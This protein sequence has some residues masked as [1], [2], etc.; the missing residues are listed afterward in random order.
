MDLPLKKQITSYAQIQDLW[1]RGLLTQAEK[2]LLARCRRGEELILN[3]GDRP[4]S[5]GPETE[6]R[7]P[8]LRYLILGGCRECRVHEWGVQLVGAYISG[9]LDLGFAKAQGITRLIACRFDKPIETLQARFELLNLS[10][11]AFPGLNG[12]D[13]KIAGDVFLKEAKTQGEV[14]LSGAEIGGQLECTGA[15]LSNESGDALNAQG[16]KIAESVFLEDAETQGEVSFAGAEIGGQLNCTGARL[17]NEG[18]DALNAQG[19]KVAGDVFLSEADTNGDV[20]FSSAE[21]GGQLECTGARLSNESGDAL[22]AQGA[23][24]AE[25]V[26][27][28]DADTKGDVRFA[29]AEIGGTLDCTGARLSNEDGHALNAQGAKVAGDVFLR[30]ADT[31]GDVRFSSAEIGGQLACNGARLTNEGGDAL[32]AQRAVTK[33]SFFWTE[34]EEISGRVDLNSSHAGDL[35]DDTESW[36][37]VSDLILDNFTYNTLYGPLDPAFRKGWLEKGA[38]VNGDF[39][40]QPYQQLAKLLRERGHRSEAREILVEKEIQQRIATRKARQNDI[41]YLLVFLEAR[42]TVPD[43]AIEKLGRLWKKFPALARQIRAPFE[44]RHRQTELRD[45]SEALTRDWARRDFKNELLVRILLLRGQMLWARCWNYLYWLT[46]AYGYKPFRSIWVAAVLIL[47]LTALSHL[48]WQN[49]DF[50]PNSDVVL[51]SSGWTEIARDTAGHG[52]PAKVWAAGPGAANGAGPGRD[53][54]TFFSPYYAA[55][56]VIPLI[57][58]G[59][60]DAWAPSTTRSWWGFSLFY[61]EKL[62]TALGW[63]VTAFFAAA[64]TGSIRRED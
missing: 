60:S 40:P 10:G 48:T 4:E 46:T 55:D 56:V 27:L 21:I 33:G 43:E 47:C 18:G 45:A 1:R 53:Y 8:L 31:N 28:E 63:I 49:G 13:A 38:W 41:A 3:G 58:L 35:V 22:N 14:S 37:K 50:A 51:T 44:A 6:I 62:F 11:S 7:A 15:R 52:N 2:R 9:P 59:Q 17:S 26:F 12:Q 32:N 23:K 20:R 42:T 24:I 39:R 54:Q 36:D 25:S 5:P 16:A 57:D 30:E 64:L 29:G 19:A 34:M 61:A